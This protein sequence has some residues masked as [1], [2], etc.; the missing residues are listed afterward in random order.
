MK[1]LK[2]LIYR[3]LSI[4]LGNFL[5]NILSFGISVGNLHKNNNKKTKPFLVAVTIDTESGYVDKDERRVWQ[6]E[7]PNAFIGFYKG[8]ENWRNLFNRYG[9]KCTFF[10]STQCFSAI[11]E[12]FLKIKKQLSFLIKEKHE[13]GL[14]VH[15]DSDFSIRK[16]L[17]KKFKHTSAKFYDYKTKKDILKISKDMLIKNLNLKNISSFRWGNWGL[18]TKSVKILEELNF[19][20]DSSAT[21]GI[22]GHL[23]DGMHYDW[24]KSNN[25]YPWFLSTKNYT[26]TKSQD[27]QILELPI[28]TFSFFGIKL[29]SDPVN[30]FLLNKAF[31]YYYQNA[32]RNKKPFVFVVISH[33][34]EAIYQNGDKTKVVDTM[35]DFIR[36]AKKFDDVRFVTLKDASSYFLTAKTK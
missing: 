29:R 8:I 9:I 23:N 4:K 21:P 25:H 28:A 10:M 35:E 7:K 13:I 11:D 32:V 14:H 27:S 12:E 24:S 20:I 3:V 17:N 33:S 19:K 5:L 26:D 36:H 31:D 2:L 22:K 15:P 18:D 34:P 16:S 30:L 1:R 6:G